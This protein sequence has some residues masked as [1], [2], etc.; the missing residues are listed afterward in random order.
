MEQLRPDQL[1]G[2]DCPGAL[3]TIEEAVAQ[4]QGGPPFWFAPAPIEEPSISL[5]REGG[6]E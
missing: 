2:L 1:D 6:T 4:A 3:H 5:A